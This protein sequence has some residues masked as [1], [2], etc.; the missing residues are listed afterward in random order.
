MI[1]IFIK[2]KRKMF[3]SPSHSLFACTR[4]SLR[5]DLRMLFSICAAAA[6]AAVR[7]YLHTSACS[8]FSSVLLHCAV[9][10]AFEYII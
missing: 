4:R 3:L 9:P 8:F 7:V 2:K 1:S 6:A 5:I 10:H